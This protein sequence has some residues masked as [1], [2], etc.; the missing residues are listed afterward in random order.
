MA[1]PAGWTCSGTPAPNTRTRSRSRRSRTTSGPIRST[2]TTTT[3]PPPARGSATSSRRCGWPRRSGPWPP[4]RR[5]TTPP[6]LKPTA[7]CCAR[8]RA[9]WAR[10][11]MR[12]SPASTPSE[13]TS[14]AAGSC[15]SAGARADPDRRRPGASRGSRPTPRSARMPNLDGGHY[16]FTALLP[17]DNHGIVEHGP[18][19]SS[20]VHMV[21]DAL[22]ALPTALQTREAEKIGIQS[23]FARSLRT[24]F[25]RIFVIDAP[26]YNGRDSLDTLL[27]AAQGVN[28]LTA[29]PVDRLACPYLAFVADFDPALDGAEEPRSWLEELWQVARPELCS[30]FRYCFQFDADGDGAAFADFVIKGQ[31]ET[32]MPFN[33]YWTITPPLPNL[34]GAEL[35]APLIGAAALALLVSVGSAID[36]VAEHGWSAG[37]AI[38]LGVVLLVVL[39]VAFVGAA[40]LYDYNLINR[41]GAKP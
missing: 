38:G 29:Q 22:E 11:A 14:T 21:R 26:A 8:R 4:I 33:D 32:T 20:A 19:K 15:T 12:P 31:L 2:P 5:P 17:I 18:F 37:A 24:H 25:V 23:P 36:V 41:R 1:F 10:P 28:P 40:L 9:R 7:R 34:T 30:V 13:P 6:S 3:T 27:A 39:G 16:F 35:F